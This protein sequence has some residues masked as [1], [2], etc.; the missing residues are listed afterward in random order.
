M[1]G[2]DSIINKVIHITLH[3]VGVGD[4]ETP[5]R[6]YDHEILKLF[7]LKLFVLDNPIYVYDKRVLTAG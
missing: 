3:I 5:S 1:I 4:R 7:E 6:S 2:L